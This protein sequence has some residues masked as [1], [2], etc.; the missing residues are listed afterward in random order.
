MGT[1]FLSLLYYTLLKNS[2]KL[3]WARVPIY[4]ASLTNSVICVYM[5]DGL[6]SLMRALVGWLAV[7]YMI[8]H[9]SLN[10]LCE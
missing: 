3:A 5:H 10:Q 8:P 1:L 4:K 6:T 7:F 2:I 9:V